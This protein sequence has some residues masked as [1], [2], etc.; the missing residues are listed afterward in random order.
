MVIL[1]VAAVWLLL[2]VWHQ[3][4]SALYWTNCERALPSAGANR[5]TSAF[6]ATILTHHVPRSL[7][8]R[9][10]LQASQPLFAFFSEPSGLPYKYF[11]STVAGEP[12]S[13]ELRELAV[14]AA[15]LVHRP[16]TFDAAFINLYESGREPHP[17]TPRCHTRQ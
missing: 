9:A 14:V 17:S 15:A 4:A 16:V 3:R 10:T 6:H 12:F 8:P 1:L 7:L 5:C 2:W 11:G 13:T